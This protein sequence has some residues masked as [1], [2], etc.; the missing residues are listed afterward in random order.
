MT[1]RP[2]VLAV[3]VA[4]S[5]CSFDPPRESPPSRSQGGESG[6]STTH[7][8]GSSATAATSSSSRGDDSS[9]ASTSS[10]AGASSASTLTST[11]GGVSTSTA[12]S[13]TSS[14]SGT[15][16]SAGATASATS[17]SGSTG[18]SSAC[19]GQTID[20]DIDRA[21][22]GTCG[23][24]CNSG[25]ECVAGQ[26]DSPI[27]WYTF[28]EGHGQTAADLAGTHDGTLGANV[29]WGSGPWGSLL[30]QSA[31]SE[32]FEAPGLIELGTRSQPITLEAWVFAD[33]TSG[34]LFH[35]TEP[36][37]GGSNAY[38]WCIPLL[39]FD[40]SGHLTTQNFW[41]G[42]ISHFSTAT[43]PGPF[44]VGGWH[45]VAMTWGALS[46][47]NLYADGA[48]VASRAPQS[49]E[50]QVR[51][52]RNVPL[53]LI[54]GS[55]RLGGAYC[56]TASVQRNAF[57]GRYDSVKVWARELSAREISSEARH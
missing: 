31:N 10:S 27:A 30:A 23:H 52:A 16:G 22:C 34:V 37:T 40:T 13:S 24:A 17:S 19:S 14:G 49:P 12:G 32:G 56:W 26:C 4:V 41:G 55:A 47:L 21:N 9:T 38:D 54:L 39:G 53:Y 42:G 50:E 36:P 20:F 46:G 2:V 6:T 3:G 29:S 7:D 45:H 8:P 48:Q 1:W 11:T 28:E 43:A 18:S 5:G 15:I 57:V 44:P 25:Q 51:E 35:E 33:A